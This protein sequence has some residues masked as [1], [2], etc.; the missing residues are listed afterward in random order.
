VAE[1][2][3][4]VGF[5]TNMLTYLTTQLHMPLAKAAT[6]LTNFGGTS[7]ATPLIGAFLADAC[8]G[9]FWTIAAASVVYQ[10]VRPGCNCQAMHTVIQQHPWVLN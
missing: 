6:T 2:L 1:K 3:A 10:V 4:V 8:I 5:S 7:A 9:R